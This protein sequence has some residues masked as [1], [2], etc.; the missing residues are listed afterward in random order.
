MTELSYIGMPSILVPYPYA[1]D[2]HQTFNA[3]VFEKAG[4]AILRQE[5]DLSAE[6]LVKDIDTILE[7]ESVYQKMSQ[8]AEAL[9]VKDAAAQICNVITGAL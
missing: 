3:N 7:K 5:S 6:S 2:D 8:Q 1:A 4:A 9:A